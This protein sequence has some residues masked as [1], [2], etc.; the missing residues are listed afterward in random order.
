MAGN[1]SRVLSRRGQNSQRRFHV[2]SR[3]LPLE[4][5]SHDFRGNEGGLAVRVEGEDIAGDE[6]QPV[7]VLV[8]VGQHTVDELVVLKQ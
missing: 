4:A 8:E 5:E 3:T 7:D 6:E 2:G 1:F